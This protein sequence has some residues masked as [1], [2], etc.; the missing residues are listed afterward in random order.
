VAMGDEL[1]TAGSWDRLWAGS[2]HRRTGLRSRLR[3]RKAWVGLLQNLL[4]VPS[5]AA[6]VLE[7]GCAPGTMIEQLHALRP[8]HRYRGIDIS[9]DGLKI[10]RQSLAD[11]GISADLDYGDI[12]DA[13][14]PLA[15]LVVSFGLAEHFT[16]PAEAMR[17]HRRFVKPGG[18]VAV[19]VPN[20]SHR[21]VVQ[22][23]RWFSPETLATHNLGIMSQTALSQALTDAGFSDVETGECGGPMLPNSRP[24][25][26]LA[27]RVYRQAA[28]AWNVGS[29]LLPEGRPWSTA[30]W[31]TGRID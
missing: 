9:E 24:R 13:E 2:R 29:T 6:D 18:H 7:L 15:D 31:A 16:D 5:G 20:Y 1:T 30:L 27:G 12:R 4:D 11:K 25:P 14:V 21:V 19:T 8:D 28:R 10:A 26:G 23:M 17:Y 22:A 3:T